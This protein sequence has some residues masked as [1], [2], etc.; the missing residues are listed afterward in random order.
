MTDLGKILVGFGVVMIVLGGILLL[1]GNLSGKV[2][3]IGRLPGDI[4]IE[5]GTW[6]F[7]FPLATSVIISIVLTLLLSLF[8]RR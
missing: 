5:R 1:A 8:G 4:Y 6:R 7:Y 2:P 3:W